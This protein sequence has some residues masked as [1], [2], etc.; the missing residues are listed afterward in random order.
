MAEN[1]ITVSSMNNLRALLTE[2]QGGLAA[3]ATKYLTPERLMKVAL[4]AA[5]RNPTL[6]KCSKRSILESLMTASQL[7]LE[8]N[9]PLGLG[10]LV[11]FYNSKTKQTECQFQLG[12]R[13]LVQLARRSGEIA[14]IDA[15]PVYERDKFDVVYGTEPKLLHEPYGYKAGEKEDRG[16]IVCFWAMTRLKNGQVIGPEIM[17]KA[18]VD[19]IMRRSKSKDREGNPVGPWRTDYA[20]MG[21]KTVLKRH[22]KHL[23]LTS[24]LAEAIDQDNRVEFDSIEVQAMDMPELPDEPEP[25]PS[26]E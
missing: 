19:E 14:S 13:G 4:V 3:V 10:Y 21:R 9:S 15:H 5:S 12:Y 6:L 25:A 8:P 18:E 1:A 2:A 7:G 26:E 23:P 22:A 11:P 20:E 17:T 16:Q 24:E